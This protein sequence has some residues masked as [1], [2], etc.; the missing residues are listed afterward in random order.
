MR[1]SLPP[2]RGRAPRLRGNGNPPQ[3]ALVREGLPGDGEGVVPGHEG[4]A[5]RGDA[6]ARTRF[7]D[8]PQR[9]LPVY[10]VHTVSVLK[11][12]VENNVFVVVLVLQQS[13]TC[14]F[15]F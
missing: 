9:R 13:L 10:H 15:S 1:V 3:P 4:R 11:C 12:F 7:R 8:G 14:L 6:R 5:V 2:R